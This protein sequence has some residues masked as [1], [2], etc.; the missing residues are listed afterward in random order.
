VDDP[1]AEEVLREIRAIPAVRA[2]R[3]VSIS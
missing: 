2:A 3:V 1:V